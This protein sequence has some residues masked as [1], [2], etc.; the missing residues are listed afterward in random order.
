MIVTKQKPFGEILG[1]LEGKQNLF[2]IGCGECSATCKTGGE[3]ELL[4]MKEKLSSAGKTVT[5]LILPKAP[6]VA[7]QVIRET[8]KYRKILETS[9]AVLVLA[10]G[11][12]VQSVNE[13]LRVKKQVYCTC[14]TL[15][16]ATLDKTGSLFC[17]KCSACGDC[18]LNLTAAIC[19]VT[20]CPKGLQNGP[21]GGSFQGKC[22]VDRDRDCAWIL[23]YNELKEKGRLDEMRQIQPPK[24]YSKQTKPRT[25]NLSA[26]INQN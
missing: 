18:V 24:D 9:D 15:F 8:A 23:I 14:D 19:P 17:E 4:E 13:N 2:L 25:L 1:Y 3:K 10:C 12:G 6:C 5:G 20:C 11:L 26:V 16:M 22:E 7:S 21:C